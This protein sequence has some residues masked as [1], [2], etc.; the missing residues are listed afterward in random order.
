[1]FYWSTFME[2]LQEISLAPLLALILPAICHIYN[3]VWFNGKLSVIFTTVCGLMV[4][5]LVD[6][7]IDGKLNVRQ[8]K[9]KRWY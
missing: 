5:M 4:S 7:V 2:F 6:I 3:C 8:V 9:P 1:M